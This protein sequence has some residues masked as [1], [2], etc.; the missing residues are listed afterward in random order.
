MIVIKQNKNI[1]QIDTLNN[2]RIYSIVRLIGA[3]KTNV[4]FHCKI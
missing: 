3:R 1:I 2:V 4:V